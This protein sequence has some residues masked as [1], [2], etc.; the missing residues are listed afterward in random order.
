MRAGRIGWL[1]GVPGLAKSLLMIKLAHDAA[2][3]R[4]AARQIYFHAFRANDP[5][6]GRAVLLRGLQGALRD[7]TAFRGFPLAPSRGQDGA[8]L[9][10]DARLLIGA[11]PELAKGTAAGPRLVVY[12]DGL[13][14][15][16]KVDPEVPRLILSLA[17]PGTTW[18]LAGRPESMLMQMLASPQVE[19]IFPAD[20]PPMRDAD[21]RAMLIEGLADAGHR[22]A[23]MDTDPSGAEP[24]RPVANPFVQTPMRRACGAPIYIRLLL[25]DLRAGRRRSEDPPERLPASLTDDYQAM[26][27]GQ[28]V[29]FDV[30]AHLGLVLAI[31]AVAAEP[32]DREA[33]ADLLHLRPTLSD[34]KR[35][36]T[37]I[38]AA[39]QLGRMLLT[40]ALMPCGNPG[41]GLYHLSLQEWL[42]GDPQRGQPP[43][44]EMAATIDRARRLLTEEEPTTGTR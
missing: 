36:L 15:V 38:D 11:I 27:A 16:A 30:N 37:W 10:A 43:A 41:L 13:D 2:N 21:V 23:A 8:D 31:L 4:K 33:L 5:Q 24:D 22:L 35:T 6:D 40:S 18:V 44:P 7:W 17:L 20:L 9:E 14:E 32:L 12:L 42:A 25:K 3:G 28:G 19:A 1:F 29:A 26:L 34:G 39:C